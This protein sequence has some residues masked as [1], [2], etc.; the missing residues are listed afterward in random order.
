MKNVSLPESYSGWPIAWVVVYHT[1]QTK[2][3]PAHVRE[4]VPLA[5]Y[6]ACGFI[7]SKIAWFSTLVILKIR[8]F[9]ISPVARFLVL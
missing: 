7:C 9:F 1:D 5:T 4:Q 3:T 6:I 8:K 2:H